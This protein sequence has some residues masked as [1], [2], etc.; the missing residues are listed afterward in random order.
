M[1]WKDDDISPDYAR[2]RGREDQRSGWYSHY[3]YSDCETQGYYDEGARE[4]RQA[5]ERERE[6]RQ[7]EEYEEQQWWELKE[8]E[9]AEQ[10]AYEAAM[11]QQYQDQ[12]QQHAEQ[13]KEESD[14]VPF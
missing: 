12:N 14:D 13:K 2:D 4:V 11:E 5:Q 3:A 6:R 9:R 1:S 10:E 7:Q 8:Q